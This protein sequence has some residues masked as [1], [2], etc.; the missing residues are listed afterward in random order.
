MPI[1][2]NYVRL[3]QQRLDPPATHAAV[4][5][6]AP[7]IASGRL[8]V[9]DCIPTLMEHAAAHGYSGDTGGLQAR[10]THAL[11]DQVE[12]ITAARN[13]AER[14]IRRA[15]WKAVE[16]LTPS[17]AILKAAQDR[18]GPLSPAEVKAIVADVAAAWLRQRRYRHG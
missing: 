18:A 6:F 8:S 12:A 5:R 9:A 2:P 1:H 16:V 15:A 11:A 14:D 13:Q 10:L 17:A 7:V 3:G 4:G